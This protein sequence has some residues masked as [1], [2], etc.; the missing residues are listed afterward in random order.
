MGIGDKNAARAL[1][2]QAIAVIPVE[3]DAFDGPA[4]IEILARLAA[5]IG[6]AATHVTLHPG[7]GYIALSG[8]RGSGLSEIAISITINLLVVRKLL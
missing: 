6:Q 7:R 1:A 5:H 4:P 3:K 2:E 8:D